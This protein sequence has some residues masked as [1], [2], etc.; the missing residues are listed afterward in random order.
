MSSCRR[1]LLL[2]IAAATLLAGSAAAQLLP[3]LP[4]G[5]V[6][7]PVGSVPVVGPALER[8]LPTEQRQQAIAPTLDTLGVGRAVASLAPDSLLELRRLRLRQLVASF[9]RELEMDGDGQP[10][11]RGVLVAI[12]PDPGSLRQAERAGFRVLAS[13]A[14]AELGLRLVTLGIP[15]RLSAREA[16]KRLRKAAPAVAADFDH[17]Y[18]PAAGAL[19][20]AGAALAVQQGGTARRTIAMIDG[21]VAAHPSLAQAAIEQRGFAGAARATG[22]GTA[23]AS[24][25]VGNHGRFRG[26]AQGARLFVADVY[27]G[28]RAAGSASAIVRS[29]AWAA[30]K[31][32]EVISISLVGPANRLLQRAVELVHARRIPMVAAVGNDGPAAPVQY[33]AGYP[34]V[35]AVTAVDARDRALPEAGRAA[36]LDFAAPGADMAAALPGSGYARVRGTSFATPLVAARLAATGSV[37]ALAREAAPGRGKVGRGVVCR[38][39]RIDPRTVGA[40]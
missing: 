12:D 37:D 22:H 3:S 30:A 36:R 10:V 2:S 8:L 27:G 20:P 39:C 31:R 40:R 14:N 6:P 32:P 38:P 25:L 26:A 28:S 23:V 35:V 19:V 9:P 15:A 24:L 4:V 21:G 29:L 17:I 7:A 13:E 11:R 33:P 18:E 34:Q 16:L 1:H 5:G